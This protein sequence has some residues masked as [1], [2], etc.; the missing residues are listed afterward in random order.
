MGVLRLLLLVALTGSAGASDPS[1]LNQRVHVLIFARTD[2]PITN[3]YAPE[4]Q[5]LDGEFAASG[6][7]FWMVYPDPSSTDADI[8]THMRAY[9]LP[10]KPLRDPKHDGEKRPK[11]PSHPKPR[12]SIKLAI[13]FTAAALMTVTSLLANLAL[14]RKLTT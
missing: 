10:G 1:A 4:L 7:D 6:V 13:W 11:L 9:K 2:C 8:A 12:F 3:R 5:R 14:P